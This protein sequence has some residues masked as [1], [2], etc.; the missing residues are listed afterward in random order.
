MD[1]VIKK[2]TIKEGIEI[3]VI[4]NGRIFDVY[5]DITPEADISKKIKCEEF[6]IKFRLANDAKKLDKTI[7]LAKKN[8]RYNN[9][10]ANANLRLGHECR[11]YKCEISLTPKVYVP[12]E[13]I[14]EAKIRKMTKP[15][16]PKRKKKKIHFNDRYRPGMSASK[17]TKYSQNN[18]TRPY[19]GGR[20]TP[21]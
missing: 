17:I 20:C 11:E 3:T 5:V 8:L 7:R 19:S 2:R 21:K 14:E 1:K 4:I 12:D 18:I 13:V 15:K 9:N 16:P 10:S 6:T